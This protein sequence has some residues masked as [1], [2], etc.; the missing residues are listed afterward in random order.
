MYL[1][2]Q[3]RAVGKVDFKMLVP[4][5]TLKR[6]LYFAEHNMAGNNLTDHMCMMEYGVLA[7]FSSAAD[8]ETAV[9]RILL[10]YQ[11]VDSKSRFICG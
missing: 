6:R 5:F 8:Q 2:L 11:V 3:E 10:A 1:S 9:E 7:A 4:V